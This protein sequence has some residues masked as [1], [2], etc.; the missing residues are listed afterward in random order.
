MRGHGLWAKL[1]NAPP[2]RRPTPA[3]RT[4]LAITTIRPTELGDRTES[5]VAVIVGVGAAGSGVA[6]GG[7][8]GI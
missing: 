1:L 7:R 4:T 2:K 6:V 8:R 5:D 3:A